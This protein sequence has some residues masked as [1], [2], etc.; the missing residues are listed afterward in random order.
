MPKKKIVVVYQYFT[1]PKGSWSTRIYELTRRWV[2]LGHEVTVI[3]APYEKSDIN[4]SRF[5]SE[6]IVDGIKLKIIN[7]AD[8]NRD[9]VFIRTIKAISFAIVSSFYTITLP[10]DIIICSSGPITVGFPGL[11]AKW[12]RKKNFVFEIRDLWPSGGIE[13]GKIRTKALINIALRFEKLIYSHASLLVTAS[14]GQK[15]NI[16]S[17]FPKI[18]VL[19]I[20]HAADKALFGP[21]KVLEILPIQFSQKFIFTHIGS[22]GFI[23]NVDFLMEVARELKAMKVDKNIGMVF[24]GEGA[25]RSQLEITK[26]KFQLNH[27]YFLGLLPKVKIPVWLH[28]SVATLFTTLDNPIQ[29]TCSPNKIYDSFA[30]GVP[31][32]QTTKGWIAKMVEKEN[33]G[34]N[35]QPGDV[36]GFAEAMVNLTQDNHLRRTK[37]AEALRVSEEVFNIEI[38]SDL[39]LDN[40]LNLV[41]SN[42]LDAIER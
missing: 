31:I 4:A 28:H 39:Y 7:S 37:A 17:R 11:L 30:S 5:I 35:I 38:L 14:E 2:A 29:D 36:R 19:V 27:V 20:P 15:N 23:H 8:S 16:I 26:N 3:T 21:K 40:L 34:I 33:C 42:N 24:I 13:M 18:S 1:T 10:S 41:P 32:I 6:R 22:L 25:E 12:L 9:S